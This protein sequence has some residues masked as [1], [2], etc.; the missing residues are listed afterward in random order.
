MRNT[1]IAGN[2]KMNLC[3]NKG[4]ELA[5]SINDYLEEKSIGSKTIIL[6]VPFTH[7]YKI[8]REI[9]TDY[10]KLAAQNC[11]FEKSG[12][13]TGE[14]SAE[15]IKSAGASHVIIGHS[16]RRQLFGDTNQIIA[17][18][19]KIAVENNLIPILC[20]GES[21]HER[22]NNEQFNIVEKQLDAVFSEISK[23]NIDKFIIAYEPVW[24]IGTG[25]NASPEQAQEMHAFIRTI[26]NKKYG[27]S[28]AEGI[29]ILYG[30]S[31]KPNNSKDLISC[32]DIDGGLIGGASLNAKDFIDIIESC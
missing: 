2:W 23:I 4:S 5:I 12:A 1:I 25:L 30:G 19:T 16:E 6:S 18:K 11:A 10:I 7:I 27:G 26:I 28:A 8:S 9:N 29:P 20:C 24:A 31:M 17:L 14:I 3:L 15:M 22:E 21:L 32:K 13:F